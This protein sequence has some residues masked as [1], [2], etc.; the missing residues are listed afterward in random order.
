MLLI[1]YVCPSPNHVWRLLV[2]LTQMGMAFSLPTVSLVSSKRY[3][4]LTTLSWLQNLTLSKLLPNP[5]W[6]SF[7]STSGTCKIGQQQRA[8]STDTSTLDD[9]L[10]PFVAWI[11]T[12]VFL[13]A[14]TVENRGTWHLVVNLM[15]PDVQSAM[16]H[17]QLNTT[18]RK[19]G[20][21]RK[22]RISTEWP[23]KK[24]SHI[25]MFSN[26]LTAKE[27]IKQTVLPVHFGVTISTESSMV[28]NNRNS[29]KSRVYLV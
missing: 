17:I 15:S 16:K 28:E 19:H 14:R 7:G 21:A 9:T 2:F 3:T 25:L 24:I 22:I 27:T 6:Q 4:C 26:V 5:T 12:L 13:S 1:A 23:P 8:L 29:F 10:Q 11:W 20:V 18:G